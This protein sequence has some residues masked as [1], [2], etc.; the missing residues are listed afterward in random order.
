MPSGS[1][2]EKGGLLTF[3]PTEVRFLVYVACIY[4]SLLYWGYLQEKI[5]SHNYISSATTTCFA[6]SNNK[7]GEGGEV[8]VTWDFPVALNLI[9]AFASHIVPAYVSSFNAM[10]SISDLSK[11]KP[12]PFTDYWYPALTCAVASPLGYAALKYISFPMMILVKVSKPVPVMV[13]GILNY[14]KKYPWW[15][16][17]AVFLLAAGIGMFSYYKTSS[18]TSSSSSSSS[19]Q[20][21]LT[22]L[23]AQLIG[24]ALVGSNLVFDGFT[25]NEQ[26]SLFKKY[27]ISSL[28]MQNYIN[29]WQIIFLF[30]YLFLGYLLYG[31]ES[32]L[33]RSY[34]ALTSS[35]ELVVDVIGFGASAAIG[36]S[37][38]F[39][40]IKEFGS[41]TWIT[42]SLTRKVFTI[43]LSVV[44]FN[45]AICMEQWIGVA[46]VFSALLLEILM[47]SSKSDS[48]TI[49][50]SNAAGSAAPSPTTL[51]LP[52]LRNPATPFASSNSS[53]N[54]RTP[55]TTHFPDI[56]SPASV[57]SAGLT[58]PPRSNSPAPE[59][60]IANSIPNFNRLTITKSITHPEVLV[61]WQIRIGINGNDKDVTDP[62]NVG[63]IKS[64]QRRAMRTTK[65]EVSFAS[66]DENDLRGHTNF[67]KLKRGPKGYVDFELLQKMND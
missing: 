45:H 15:K 56:D 39:A 8:F 6:N 7:K 1:D 2:K 67:L 40:V 53:D 12:A 51:N 37:T 62:G 18:K 54:N 60:S 34:L 57:G 64:M 16:Y 59:M 30:G 50:D 42:I 20:M 22:P 48:A 19:D 27:T 11:Y 14:G 46:L 3:L 47:T 43:L 63:V 13:I 26:D 23:Q 38:I 55:T 25:N 10:P 65:Y 29:V 17:T 33:S 4:V 31:N 44:M 35:T 61:G 28:D 36:Q 9:M 49:K 24:V 41:L 32:E 66:R 58:P 5:M 21:G 52:R